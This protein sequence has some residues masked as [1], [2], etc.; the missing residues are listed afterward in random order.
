MP[1]VDI[2]GNSDRLRKRRALRDTAAGRVFDIN[3]GVLYV[4]AM[5]SLG[6]YGIVLAGW[7]SVVSSFRVPPDAK[8]VASCGSAWPQTPGSA[9]ATTRMLWR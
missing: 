3:V 6:V 8:S 7:A 9:S 1:E 4:L 5:S 2:S